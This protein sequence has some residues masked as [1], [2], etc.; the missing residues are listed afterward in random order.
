VS[1]I[2]APTAVAKL[3]PA[4]CPVSRNFS[5][6]TPWKPAAFALMFSA[7]RLSWNI[8]ATASRMTAPPR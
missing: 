8:E 7:E 2:R 3:P 5:G 6:R 1:V 4:E